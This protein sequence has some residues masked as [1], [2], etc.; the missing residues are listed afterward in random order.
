MEQRRDSVAAPMTG[1][2]SA[3][4]TGE[5]L[6]AALE[7]WGVSR[8]G[9]LKFCGLM[10]ATLA[11][12]ASEAQVIAEALES[13]PR[14]PVIWLEFQDCTGDRVVHQSRAAS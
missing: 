8:R 3:V 11:L 1:T 2:V 4:D 12:P 10:A 6:G 13:A 7:R 9:F 5:T 14:L